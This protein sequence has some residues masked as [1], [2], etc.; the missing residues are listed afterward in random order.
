MGEQPKKRK[1]EKMITF[2]VTKPFFD[3]IKKVADDHDE[4][5][6]MSDLI[7]KGTEK[8]MRRANDE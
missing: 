3:R 7:R 5:T 6:N 8:E 2:L 1:K 4:Y